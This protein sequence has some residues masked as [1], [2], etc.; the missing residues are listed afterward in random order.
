MIAAPVGRRVGH[1]IATSVVDDGA[2]HSFR[3]STPPPTISVRGRRPGVVIVVDG[4]LGERGAQLL[5]EVL[6]A[7]LV[8]VGHAHH[9]HVDVRRLLTDGRPLPSILPQL[10]RA[11][12]SVTGPAPCRSGERGRS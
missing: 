5:E 9:I 2:V 11:G 7:A 3:R 1:A 12:A 8:A 4:I 6:Q 10:Q